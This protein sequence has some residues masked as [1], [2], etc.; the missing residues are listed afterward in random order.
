MT[1]QQP[2]VSDVA[3]VFEGG[4]MRGSYTAATIPVLLREKLFFPVVCGI[5]AGSSNT[6]NYVSQSPE[7]AK[8]TFVDF[9]TDPQFGSWR[10][11]VRGQG[12][13]N[14]EY[15]YEHSAGPEEAL[16]LNFDEFHENRADVRIGAFDIELGETVYWSKRDMPELADMARRVRASSTMPGLMPTVT[17]DGRDYV[18]GA[19][20]ENGGIALDAAQEAGFERFFVVLTRPAGYRKRAPRLKSAYAAWF[21]K[22][23][24]VAEGLLQ[25]HVNYNRQL[26]ELERLEKE[27]RAYVFRPWHM[28]IGNQERRL[29]HLDAMFALGTYQAEREV[30]RWHEF[31]GK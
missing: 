29:D 19:V 7:R 16:P 25:R 24:T 12:M 10:T 17:I 26:D 28:L 1:I 2:N 3:L 5:S 20:G 21:R 13:F 31:L 4:G 11:W 15:I 27:G 22:H 9:V 8:R 18:D 6:I 30:E 14:A 23:P